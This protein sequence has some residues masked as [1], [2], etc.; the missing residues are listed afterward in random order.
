MDDIDFK[1]EYIELLKKCLTHSLWPETISILKKRT[2][3]KS[4]R[5]IIGNILAAGLERFNLQL[6]RRIP[7]DP[8]KYEEGRGWPL[9]AETMIGLKRLNNIQYCVEKI[10]ANGIP[11]DFI[12]TGIWRGGATIFMRALLNAYGQNDRSIWAADSFA[13]LPK[14]NASKYPEDTGDQHYKWDELS[15]NIDTVKQNFAKYDLL[16]DQVKFL[17]GWFKD[18]LPGAPI[19]KLALLRIDGDIYESTMDALVHL[20]PKVS[21][22]GFVIIDDFTNKSCIKAVTDYRE[23]YHVYEEIEKIDWTGVFWQKLMQH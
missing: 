6:V 9:F 11:G 23:K 18:T 10:I 14:P 15:V 22:G 3:C 2:G 21:P 17:K 16:D 12:E 7:P 4:V 5:A 13:G 8:T 20:Y 1:K 19:T